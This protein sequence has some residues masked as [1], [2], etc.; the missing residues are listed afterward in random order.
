MIDAKMSPRMLCLARANGD[1]A[2][3]EA[4][5]Q[6]GDVEAE[7]LESQQ[8]DDRPARELDEEAD[9]ADRGRGARVGLALGCDLMREP[10]TD[11][12]AAPEGGLNDRRDE[13]DVIDE[14]V[15][16]G[17]ERHE[18]C[19]DEQAS[20][21]EKPRLR[22]FDRRQ[23]QAD[24]PSALPIG[25]FLQDAYGARP[26]REQHERGDQGRSASDQPVQ[27]SVAVEALLQHRY[28]YDGDA[29]EFVPLA[30]IAQGATARQ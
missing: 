30:R 19:A 22:S 16:F 1:A 2:D 20:N 21:D 3:A 4:G 8:H 26:N 13:R 6:R 9:H 18:L 17:R 14:S 12:L 27:S 24:A 23:R 7:I 11:R 5:K 25:A 15:G 29:P 10:P 28:R